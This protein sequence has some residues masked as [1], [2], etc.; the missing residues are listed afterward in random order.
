[1]DLEAIY[2]SDEDT[3]GPRT[4]SYSQAKGKAQERRGSRCVALITVSLGL[5]CVLLL[6][7]I[8]LQHNTITAERDLIKSYKNTAE[9]FNQTI[10]SLQ[11]NY[12]DL[13]T[14]KHQLQ[15]NFNTLSQKK[16]ELETRVKDLTAEKD[17]LQRR[18]ES[19]NQ[20]KLELEKTVSDLNAEK[21][22]LQRSFDSLNKKKLELES[23]VTS[24]S[25]ELKKEST[26]QGWFFMSNEEKSWSDSRQ[27]CRDRGGDLVIINSEEKQRFISSLTTERVWI[28][29]SDIEHESKMT[30]VDNSPLNQG[31][32]LKGGSRCLVLITVSLGLIC[33]LLLVFIILQHITIT[34]ERDLIKSY[35]NTAEEFNQT[36]NSLQNNY[37]ELMTEK[38]QLQNKFNSLSQKK[39]KLETRV[40]SLSDELKK[41]V[42]DRGNQ[43]SQGGFFISKKAMSW[44]GSRQYCRNRGADLVIINSEEKQHNTI[45]AERDLIKSYKNTAEELNQTINSLQD[46]CTDR[47]TTPKRGGSRC[48]V[49]ITVSLGLIS[50][51]LLV[52]IILQHITITAERD[53]IKSYKNTAEEFNQTINS[54][55]NNYTELMTEKHQL[56]NNFTSLN[57]KK[58]ELEKKVKDLNAEK[59]QSQRSFDSLNKKK[60]ELESRVTSLSEEL[61]TES[62]KRGWFFM[63]NES[64]SWS[65]SRQYCR[66][67][68]AD[69]VIINSEEKQR[70]ISSLTTERVWIGL[71]DIDNE[72]NM[73]WVDNSSLNQTFWF[74]DLH[75]KILVIPSQLKTAEQ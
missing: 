49:L 53:L 13:M 48:L 12:T 60:L 28:G 69:L 15:N 43:S 58:L 8:I 52:F 3:T 68:G 75:S 59:G 1:M 63:P 67:H 64:K 26:K 30:W 35:K 2:E 34:A 57:E 54:L 21:D 32:W 16:L 55:Q 47:R 70:F 6:V 4:S 71:S 38:H 65:D 10:N 73:K 39:L 46:N 62:T 66:D 44:S 27:Y 29:L 37:T 61:K 41:N 40:I 20:K 45:T 50:V 19:L 17:Q 14:E 24:L 25:E 31:F 74:K 51:L 11:D 36:I 23:K 56:Q 7:F 72:G 33:V 42:F 5:I 18:A 9:E 22:Q